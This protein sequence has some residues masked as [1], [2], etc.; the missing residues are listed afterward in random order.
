MNYS[1]NQLRAAR[2]LLGL[3]QKDFAE[4]VG[5]GINTIRTMEG[6]G[7]E[8]VG[9]FASTRNKVREALEALGIEFVN[10]DAP[11]VIWLREGGKAAA[12]KSTR[13]AR[14]RGK[15]TTQPKR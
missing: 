11:G 10:G 3:D 8:P 5:V 6:C 13:A 4:A 9:G 7:A 15:K 14:V 12:G 2:V 1:G